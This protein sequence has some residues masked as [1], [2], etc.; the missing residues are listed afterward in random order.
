MMTPSEDKQ[1]SHETNPG[2]MITHPCIQCALPEKLKHCGNDFCLS[3]DHNLPLRTE[4]S[5]L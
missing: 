5:P 2:E 1:Q 3:T 4:E